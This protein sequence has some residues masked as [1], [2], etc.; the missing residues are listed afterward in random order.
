MYSDKKQV[1]YMR[2]QGNCYKIFVNTFID[3]LHIPGFLSWFVLLCLCLCPSVI[4]LVFIMSINPVN[5]Q[6]LIVK[7]NPAL[8]N[9]IRT[10]TPFIGG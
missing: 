1:N 6:R 8:R 7:L 9:V 10:A 2:E 3:Y 5:R 4:T